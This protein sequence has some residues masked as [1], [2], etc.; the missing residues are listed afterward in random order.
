MLQM[1]P[2]ISL[3]LLATYVF[4]Y[5]SYMDCAAALVDA[6][7]LSIR[8]LVSEKGYGHVQTPVFL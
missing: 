3:R 7:T 8:D 1:L 5:L 2:E 6:R 4:P